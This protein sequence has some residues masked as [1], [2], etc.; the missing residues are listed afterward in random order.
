[1][2]FDATRLAPLNGLI[3]IGTGRDAAEAAVATIF[4]R[5]QLKSM[6]V[7]CQLAPG[8]SFQPITP[9]QSTDQGVSLEN[10]HAASTH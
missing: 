8:Q 2:V 1:M 3:R 4:G 6:K 10:N 9:A 7:D 5:V